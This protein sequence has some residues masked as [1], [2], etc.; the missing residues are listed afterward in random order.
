LALYLEPNRG[1]VQ[2][3]KPVSTKGQIKWVGLGAKNK[4]RKEG[5]RKSLFCKDSLFRDPGLD[6]QEAR[7]I[8]TQ[9][10]WRGSSQIRLTKRRK[11]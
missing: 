2:H 7:K 8:K 4:R 6:P 3:R 11:Q 9:P 10:G 5:I 1:E